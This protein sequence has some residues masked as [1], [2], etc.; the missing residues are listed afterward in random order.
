MRSAPRAAI[1]APPPP[2]GR[3][4]APATHAGR[5]GAAVVHHEARPRLPAQ[6][7]HL[8]VEPEAAAPRPCAAGAFVEGIVAI[9]HGEILLHDLN[10]RGLGNTNGRTAIRQPVMVGVAT[11]AATR[12]LIHYEVPPLFW[13]MPAKA[14]VPA[15]ACRGGGHT[16]G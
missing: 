8:I 13:I 1:P 14:E 10:R 7:F 12:D 11:I 6:E 5:A 3:A 9:E 2:P 4:R 15:G 16:V